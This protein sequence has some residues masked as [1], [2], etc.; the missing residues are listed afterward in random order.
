MY[1]N[2][3]CAIFSQNDMSDFIPAWPSFS[4]EFLSYFLSNLSFHAFG[5]VNK[6]MMV[7]S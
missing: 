7:F 1:M 2:E 4:M 5:N 6:F 3:M